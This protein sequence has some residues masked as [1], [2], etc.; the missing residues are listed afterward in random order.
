MP[1]LPLDA[2]WRTFSSPGAWWSAVNGSIC[3]VALRLRSEFSALFG[4]ISQCH[5]YVTSSLLQHHR[6]LWR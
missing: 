5:G 1:R 6:I 2:G 3:D 4:D